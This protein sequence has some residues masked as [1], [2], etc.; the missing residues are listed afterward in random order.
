MLRATREAMTKSKKFLEE[1]DKIRE[2]IAQEIERMEAL[3]N[4]QYLKRF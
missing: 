1:A 4:S 3:L 2:S